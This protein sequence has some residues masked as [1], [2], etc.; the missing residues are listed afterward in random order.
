MEV[1]MYSTR[2]WNGIVLLTLAAIAALAV[3]R[4]AEAQARQF[5]PPMSTEALERALGRYV[6]PSPEAMQRIHE[7]HDR[8]LDEFRR[9]EDNE[10]EPFAKERPPFMRGGDMEPWMRKYTSLRG[11]VNSIDG[12]LLNEIA[13]AVD[14]SQRSSVERVRWIRETEVLRTGL[15]DEFAAMIGGGS[16]VDLSDVLHSAQLTDEQLDRVDPLLRDYQSRMLGTVRK[17]TDEIERTVMDLMNR[18]RDAGLWGQALQDAQ[19]DPEKA[20]EMYSKMAQFMRDFFA[21]IT[22][23]G[24]PIAEMNRKSYREMRGRFTFDELV[25]VHPRW[26]SAAYPS[27]THQFPSGLVTFA[28]RAKSLPEA[29]PETK[30]AIDR[31][32]EESVRRVITT[33][34]QDETDTDATALA[35]IQA[36]FGEDQEGGTARQVWEEQRVRMQE[37]AE[38]R[39]KIV[40]AAMDAITAQFPPE[41]AEKLRSPSEGGANGQAVAVTTAPQ[42]VAAAPADGENGPEGDEE[43]AAP[44]AWDAG[45][46][47]EN[48]STEVKAYSVG[49]LKRFLAAIDAEDS[50][51][52][53]AEALHGDYLSRYNEK[54]EALRTSYHDLRARSYDVRDGSAQLNS[55]RAAEASAVL[56]NLLAAS[57]DTDREFFESLAAVVGESHRDMVAVE[58]ASRITGSAGRVVARGWF[59]MPN[60]EQPVD[61]VAVIRGVELTPEEWAKVAPIVAGR[62]D[63]LVSTS[64]RALEANL[65]T[66]AD[67]ERLQRELFSQDMDTQARM[68]AGLEYQERMQKLS[69]SVK[70]VNDARLA[71]QRDALNA[72]LDALPEAKRPRLQRAWHTASYPSLFKDP[73]ALFRTFEK[74]ERMPDLTDAQHEQV[75]K[76]LAEYQQ[77]YDLACDGLVAAAAVPL[78]ESNIRDPEHWNRIQARER[79]IER[80]KF[81][82]SETT[83][84]AASALRQILTPEQIAHF[85]QLA[86]PSKTGATKRSPW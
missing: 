29:T 35:T 49:D 17:S 73:G 26:L 19:A 55:E 79:T 45:L 23:A 54:V 62:A 72:V 16:R 2:R 24:A 40:T 44:N 59:F 80:M 38:E 81:E 57:K 32:L 68:R 64:E 51:T 39:Q 20:M 7:A 56:R 5:P 65:T 10:L 82:R 28:E 25:K 43:T 52:T 84:R 3:P 6:R 48:V 31:I 21:S 58:Q 67:L 61:V 78:G 76:A 18:M 8:Y 74:I 46:P 83:S 77:S 42:E 33:L 66:A 30:E 47:V 4:N 22:A 9:L 41:L 63:A 69:A 70:T 53:L 37:A 71:A 1:G 75:K 27:L 85:R 12:T 86:D 36:Q 34:D 13:Q 60:A 15:L 14:E 50:A 11:R